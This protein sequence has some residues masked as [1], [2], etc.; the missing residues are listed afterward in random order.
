[1]WFATIGAYNGHGGVQR[2]TPAAA[3]TLFP[4]PNQGMIQA[5]AAEPRREPVVPRHRRRGRH[6]PQPHD[7]CQGDH[8]LSSASGHRSPGARVGAAGRCGEIGPIDQNGNVAAYPVPAS[9]RST[10]SPRTQRNLWFTAVRSVDTAAGMTSAD[11]ATGSVTMFRIPTF[12]AVPDQIAAGP[13]GN[14]WFGD[15]QKIGRITPSGKFTEFPTHA[16]GRTSADN[17]IAGPDHAMCLR[18][19]QR[20][21]RITLPARSPSSQLPARLELAPRWPLATATRCGSPRRSG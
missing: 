3:V 14:V 10:H 21:R 20:H 16:S 9:R 2:I 13:D 1:M 7:D 12:N 18:R 4:D 17:L 8:D 5:L 15:T 11:D 19:R 6:D